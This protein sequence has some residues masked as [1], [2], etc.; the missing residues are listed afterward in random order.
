MELRKV[1]RVGNSTFVGLPLAFQKALGL[2]PGEYV[3]LFMSDASTLVIRKHNLTE[4]KR[5]N[6]R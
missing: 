3:E 5:T 2:V 1:V 4:R 6:D